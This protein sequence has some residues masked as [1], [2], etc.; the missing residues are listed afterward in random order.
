MRLYCLPFVLSPTARRHFTCFVL[1]SLPGRCTLRFIAGA[2]IQFYCDEVC[3]QKLFFLPQ[4]RFQPPLPPKT[5]S[6]FGNNIQIIKFLVEQIV[7]T[8]MREGRRARMFSQANIWATREKK[9][10]KLLMSSMEFMAFMITS[11]HIKVFESL[12]QLFPSEASR[13][14]L[15]FLPLRRDKT[16]LPWSVQSERGKKF[17][18]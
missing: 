6:P 4:T 9:A 13:C 14:S 2:I 10:R 5:S 1:F 18:Q 3:P 8:N 11:K 17:R 7:K 16:T 12:Q 15:F